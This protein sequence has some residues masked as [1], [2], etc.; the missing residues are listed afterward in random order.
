LIQSSIA[1]GQSVLSSLSRRLD[2]RLDTL[3]L[4]M[5]SPSAPRVPEEMPRGFQALESAPADLGRPFLTGLRQL[6]PTA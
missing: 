3:A 6:R 1:R 2:D 5:A 4:A